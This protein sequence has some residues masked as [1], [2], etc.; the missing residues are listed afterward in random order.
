MTM[1]H[2]VRLTLLLFPFLWLAQA[3][4]RGETARIA[5]VANTRGLI[6]FWD[7]TRSANG[8]WIAHHDPRVTDRDFPVVLRRI[9]DPAAY[10]PADWPYRDDDSRLIV[11]AGGPF[12]RAVRFNQGHVFAEVPRAAFDGTPLDIH[13]ERPFTLLAWVRFIGARHL[14]AGVWDEGGWDRYQGRRQYALFGGLFGTQGVTAHVSATGAAS[15]PQSTVAGAQYARVKA[16]DGA[17]FAN[18]T[19]MCMGMSFDPATGQVYAY[20]DGVATPMAYGDR[21]QQ[22]V[23]GATGDEA[24]NPARLAWPL[25]GSRTFVVKFNGYHR[26]D[27]GV[28]EH[29]LFV[30][31]DAGRLRYQRIGTPPPGRAFSVRVEVRRGATR[32]GTPVRWTVRPGGSRAAPGLRQARLGDVV[33]ASLWSGGRQV[34]TDV[35]RTLTEGAPFTFGRALGLGQ[36]EPEHG[37]QLEMSGVAVFNRVL[38]R[39]ELASLAFTR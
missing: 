14:V 4:D 31:L 20:L 10:A 15:F 36:D 22:D 1:T 2:G 12:G 29:A 38:N 5:A 30:D 39:A 16:L 19:W 6:A 7:F 24:I 25:F 9:G 35:T 28:G 18:E 33:A 32:I 21:V 27:G 26:R 34:G 3:P 8:R 11:T 13:G 37:S 17:T 23:T